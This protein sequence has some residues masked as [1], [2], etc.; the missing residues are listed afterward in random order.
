MIHLT[1][2]HGEPIVVNAA[3]IEFLESTPDTMIALA[4]GRRFMVRET[5]DEV[6][7]RVVAFSSRIGHP[8]V[9]YRMPGSAEESGA[10][11]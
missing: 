5:I 7:D 6:I 10:S 3:L 9:Q 1:L 4:T 8:V 2:L 11:G